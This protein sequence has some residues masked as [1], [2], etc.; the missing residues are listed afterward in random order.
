VETFY[1]YCK[2]ILLYFEGDKTVLAVFGWIVWHWLQRIGIYASLTPHTPPSK[3]GIQ[4]SFQLLHFH[5]WNQ[6]SFVIKVASGDYKFV[7]I[8]TPLSHFNCTKL[9]NPHTVLNYCRTSSCTQ[10]TRKKID[11]QYSSIST[12]LWRNPKLFISR[13]SNFVS[14]HFHLP[15]CT[16]PTKKGVSL[17]L[18]Q[19]HYRAFMYLS[20]NLEWQC[21]CSSFVGCL[22]SVSF[23]RFR[24]PG[25]PVPR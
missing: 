22:M 16:Y 12:V 14:S 19:L 18:L 17:P 7:I 24:Q 20:W 6:L 4:G 9:D 3:L 15:S 10:Y 2:A 25:N 8:R 21:E 11:S 5:D 1:Q 13:I 23:R